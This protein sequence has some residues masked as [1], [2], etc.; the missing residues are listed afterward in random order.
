MAITYP[1]GMAVES[2]DELLIRDPITVDENGAITC[3][4]EVPVGSEVRLL[5]GNKEEAIKAAQEAANMALKNIDGKEPAC[6]IVFN[7]IA[8]NKLFGRYANDE[9]E[10]IK[11]VLGEDTPIIGF[12]TYGEVA[13]FDIKSDSVCRFH[14]E[15]AVITVIAK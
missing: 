9:I 1:I 7:C 15:T 3:A 8:R 4:A 14:N 12:Y 6:A 11:K 2:S 10:A 5:I 13:P